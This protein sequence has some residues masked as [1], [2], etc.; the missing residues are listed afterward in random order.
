MKKGFGRC[1]SKNQCYEDTRLTKFFFTFFADSWCFYK[2]VCMFCFGVINL[3]QVVTRLHHPQLS[4]DQAAVVMAAFTLHGKTT[5]TQATSPLSA[6]LWQQRSAVKCFKIQENEKRWQKN[7]REVH[8]S[9]HHPYSWTWLSR[10]SSC[11]ICTLPQCLNRIKTAPY[12]LIISIIKCT[13]YWY[14][15][16]SLR[17]CLVNGTSLHV[18]TCFTTHGPQPSHGCG[19]VTKWPWSCEKVP[20]A[21]CG[22]CLRKKLTLHF[23]FSLYFSC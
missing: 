4:C 22:C 9:S 6:A 15:D 18:K 10:N 7:K 12:F 3:Q 8:S 2:S 1:A 19:V 11:L 21:F 13:I 17:K 20:S 16:L 14:A 5:T 23:W